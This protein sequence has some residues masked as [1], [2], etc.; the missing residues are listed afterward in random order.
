MK[1]CVI[2]PRMGLG[3]LISFIAHFK[4][5][6]KNGISIFINPPKSLLFEKIK[7]STNRPLFQNKKNIKKKVNEL[8]ELRKTIYKK[9]NYII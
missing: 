5:I 2:C 8:Y 9:S 6:S 4:V 3:D 1:T 7:N